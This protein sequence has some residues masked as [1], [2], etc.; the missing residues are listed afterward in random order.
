MTSAKRVKKECK[1]RQNKIFD[2]TVCFADFLSADEPLQSTDGA[3]NITSKL[4]KKVKNP[5]KF[6]NEIP[7]NGWYRNNFVRLH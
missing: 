2:K 5:S 6:A 4:A 3:G 1:R 7:S